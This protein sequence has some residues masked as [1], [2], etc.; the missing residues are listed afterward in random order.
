VSKQSPDEA[1]LQLIGRSLR[2][3]ASIEIGGMGS[4]RLDGN[5]QIVF[6]PTGNPL[7]FLAYAQ[8]DRSKVKKLYRAL[9]KAGV[10]PWM[11]CQTL[12]PG[13]N[14]PRAIEQTIEISDFFL[15][16]FSSNSVSKRG[17]FQSELA[18][19]L[20]VASR[21]PRSEVFF[22]PV[23][24][25]DCELPRHIASATHWVDLFPNWNRGVR[26]LISALRRQKRPPESTATPV[27]KS[28][29]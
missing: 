14:W 26:R 6:H 29:H 7:V 9:R 8:E 13:Q 10:N 2:E 18:F 11:D 16:C 15:G 12:L 28:P 23:R 3:G 5:N 4:F 19:A 21:F 17:H 20:E 24:L 25:D 27:P 1:L 22:V